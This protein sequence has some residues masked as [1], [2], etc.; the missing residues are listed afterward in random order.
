MT[1]RKTKTK[2]PQEQYIVGTILNALVLIPGQDKDN[3]VFPGVDHARR[4]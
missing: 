4:E 1:Q 3:P 2:L